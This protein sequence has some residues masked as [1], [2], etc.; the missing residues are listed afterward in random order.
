MNSLPIY[1]VKGKHIQSNERERVR[2]R[3]RD[4]DR[5]RIWNGVILKES[6]RFSLVSFFFFSF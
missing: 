6:F 3:D 2:E 1:P 4:R 5:E